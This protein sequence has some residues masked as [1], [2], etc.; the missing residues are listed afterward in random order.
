MRR[1][2]VT[3]GLIVVVLAAI[4]SAGW[5]ALAAW[6]DGQVSGVLARIKDRG[7]EVDCGGRDMVGFPFALKVACGETAL[8]EP[9]SGAHALL[10]GLTGG[11][12]I[13][14]P[15]TAQIALASPARVESPL[16]AAPADLSWNDA[17]VDVAMNLN[18]PQAVSFDA[19]DFAAELP[20]PD[21]LAS[22]AARSAAGTLAPA[23]DGG[24]DADLSFTQ[25]A[26]SLAG[27]T[28]PAFDGRASAWVSVPPRALLA[29]RAG[30]QAPLSARLIGGSFAS[31]DARLDADGDISIDEEGVLDGVITLRIAGAEALPGFIAALPPEL[32]KRA[33][34]VIGGMIAF[35]SP[36]S[37]DGTPGSELRVEIER[38]KARVGPVTVTL[39]RLPL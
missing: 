36:T 33:N 18:G 7:I 30:L 22:V 12:S 37:L 17:D 24:S 31:G 38:G 8:A 2:I 26:L 16:L 21:L 32:Q 4:W 10:A 34:Q 29:G 28:F 19:E 6:A 1:L 20:M 3:L 14:A 5:F 25:L 15:R 27:T 39:P 13:F 9:G 11:A 23:E 35:G